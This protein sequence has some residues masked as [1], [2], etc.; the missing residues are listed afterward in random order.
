MKEQTL[1]YQKALILHFAYEGHKFQIWSKKLKIVIII[2]VVVF[3]SDYTE[4]DVGLVMSSNTSLL[5]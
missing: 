2:L 1:I 4:R 3:I 5:I